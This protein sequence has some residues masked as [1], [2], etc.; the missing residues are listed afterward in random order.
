MLTWRHVNL[1]STECARTFAFEPW[2]T[3]SFTYWLYTSKESL[4]LCA[5]LLKIK[6]VRWIPDH[7]IIPKPQVKVI[8]H[9]PKWILSSLLACVYIWSTGEYKDGH[10]HT[11]P[12]KMYIRYTS[13]LELPSFSTKLKILFF[14][15]Y[16]SVHYWCCLL[17][18]E[19]VA[20]KMLIKCRSG[21]IEIFI[22]GFIT[23]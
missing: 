8:P 5:R 13:D 3:N 12:I 6:W 19:H 22:I 14:F 16:Q 2:K 9:P 1:Q 7:K 23:E 17:Y 15:F 20:I 11:P 4:L 21:S 18:W 10:T